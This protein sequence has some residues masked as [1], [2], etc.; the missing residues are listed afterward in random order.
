MYTRTTQ[1]RQTGLNA[2]QANARAQGEMDRSNDE[3]VTAT[4]ELDATRYGDLLKP[5][6]LVGLRGVGLLH[7]GF[8]YVKQVTH[9]VSRGSYKQRFTLARE[10]LGTTTPVVRP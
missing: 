1:F 6:S 7:D 10:G 9:S 4:G 5:R 2:M 3:V 8:Y